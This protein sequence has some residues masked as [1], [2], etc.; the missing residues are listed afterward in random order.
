MLLIDVARQDVHASR[1]LGARLPEQL[2]KID[3]SDRGKAI[4]ILRFVCGE[5]ANFTPLVLQFLPTLM[6]EY[7]DQ[8]LSLYLSEALDLFAESPRKAKA[9]LKGESLAAH[10]MI[11]EVQDVLYFEE[12]SKNMLLYARAHCG[13]DIQIQSGS[14]AFTDGHYIFLPHRIDLDKEIGRLAYRALTA[15]NAGYI[16]FGTLDLELDRIEGVWS[17]AREGELDLERM[18]RSFPNSSM[19]RDLFTIFENY[20]V[21]ICVRREYPGVGRVMDSLGELWIPPREQGR[22]L[23]DAEQVIDALRRHVQREEALK[24]AGNLTDILHRAI[25]FLPVLEYEGASVA[26]TVGAVQE[27]FPLVYAL[28]DFSSSASMLQERPSSPAGGGGAS[29]D[30]KSDA[31]RQMESDPR[32]GSLDFSRL[33]E[34][35]RQK[36]ARARAL[37]EE[38]AQSGEEISLTQ[39][40][41][42]S[43]MDFAETSAFLDRMKGPRGP[44][45]EDGRIVT[46]PREPSALQ[47]VE[48]VDILPNAWLYPE[49]DMDIEDLKPDWTQVREFRLHPSNLDFSNAVMA[50]YA[51]EIKRIRRVFEALRPEEL[52]KYRGLEDGED[53]DFDRL[54]SARVSR[55]SGDSPTDRIYTRRLRQNRDTA[56]AFLLDMSSSTNELANTDG[57]RILDVEKEALVVISEAVEAIGDRFAIFGFSGYGRDQVAFYLAKE[58]HQPWDDRAMERIGQMS[59]K[60]ENRDGAAIRHCTERM[61]H[62]PA[63]NKLL[64]LLSDGKPLDCGCTQYS[65][66][67]AQRDTRAAL[68]E[69]RKVGIQ[70]FC[71]TVDPYGQDYLAEMYGKNGYIVIDRVESLPNKISRIYRK[72]TC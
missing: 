17:P 43:R 70:P 72:L 29:S 49:W 42:Q 56:V 52:R 39:A 14:G 58:L 31:Y 3:A 50:E 20:R 45:R 62:W 51:V 41:Q 2:A 32:Q 4:G 6:R 64:I 57:K 59:W 18:L 35:E 69:A 5:S 23:T 46:E 30:G 10:R 66:Q 53:L 60:M 13:E 54:I 26:T 9:F 68:Q 55:R 24:L 34:Q 47:L 65:D 22:R 37:K 44:M 19:A 71:I 61:R 28:L 15:R 63:R 33:S 11:K 40:R 8:Q 67:Y 27:V 25:Q 1:Q 7:D 16:E 38:M 36:E 48:S 12:V 21:E